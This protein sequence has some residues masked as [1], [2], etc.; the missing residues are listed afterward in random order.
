MSIICNYTFGTTTFCW[1]FISLSILFTG[2]CQ[3]QEP[4]PPGLQ[5]VPDE[6]PVLEPEEALGTFF[7]PPGYSIELVAAEP[8]V[9]D[10]VAIDFDAEGRIWVAEMRGYMPNVDAEG[11]NEP[12]GKIVVLEDTTGDGV[13]DKKTVYMDNLVLPRALKV[14]DSGVLVAAPPY[15]WMTRDTTGNLQADVVEVL[16][17][18]YGS[19]DVNPEVNP[20]GLLWGL[21]NWIYNTRYRGR[22]YYENGELLKE[23][24]RSLGQWGISM[25]DYGYIY[26]NSNE[27]PIAVDH[28]A[29]HYYSRNENLNRRR[30]VYES[31]Y[32]NRNIWPIRS[33][34]GVN[35]GY[36]TNVVLHE[37]D[38][39][40][41]R[42]TAA[43]SLAAY[44][45]DRLPDELRGDV[46][47][48]DP[49]GNLVQRFEIT[50]DRL[51]N[52][53]AR[54]PYHDIKAAFLSS[55]DE[56]FR[57][58]NI[59]SAPDGTLYIVD[60]Y[61][62][63]IQHR[64]YLTDYLRNEIRKRDLE[65]PLGLGRIYRIVHESKEPDT[66]PQFSGKTPEE[67]VTYLE[68]PNGWWRDT[69]QRLLV[70]RQAVSVSPELRSLVTE[71]QEDYTRLQALWTL[72]G[73]HA[74]DE[75]ILEQAMQDSSPHVRAAAIR[76]AEP[77]ISQPGNTLISSALNLLDDD[78]SVVRRQLAASLGELPSPQREE[79][80]LSVINRYG[81]DSL[82]VSLVVSGLSGRELAFLNNYLDQNAG[83]TDIT[84]TV[85]VVETLAVTILRS[86][87]SED[88]RTLLELPADENRPF[89]QRLSVLE[90][91]DDVAP[92][93]STTRV[94][95]LE[96]DHRPSAL[97]SLAEAD[98]ETLSDLASEVVER[99][100][101]P[102]K[103]KPQLPEVIPLTQAEQ[104]RFEQ[105]E[106]LFLNT[107]T[108]CHASDGQET[109]MAPSLVDS[110]WVLGRPDKLLRILLQGLEGEMLMP[111]VAYHSDEE[112]AAI[113]TY[114][115]RAWGNNASPVD[116]SD[117]SE[118]R[119]VTTGRERPW[120][121][122][123]L[124]AIR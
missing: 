120:T 8:L 30:G 62:G 13:M 42:F 61:R 67:L 75:E 57:P 49:A 39:T 70:E 79:A 83:K 34:S 98:Q 59:S 109:D 68:H 32:E 12:V 74:A 54:N 38:S 118:I 92:P 99:M 11:E 1:L 35:R 7:L 31:I 65:K 2:S 15:L 101:W 41:I 45:G 19:P 102:G 64:Y 36:R 48:P 88:I 86:G 23:D 53:T 89:W 104:A 116:P 95:R 22:F 77:F 113:V 63:V 108:A 44:R 3:Q 121:R 87:N 21:D 85:D 25:D 51:G 105:G 43:S 81:N 14:L 55:T 47:V 27:N 71:G 106:K 52:L 26:R 100:G 16:R 78:R 9:E 115:R 84:G 56:R 110:E 33:N 112:L 28:T 40:L 58:V 73:L 10:P 24:A 5:D 20:N 111:P 17:D 93:H 76:I 82:V 69:A 117:V 66:K 96:L 124:E 94:R 4:W 91:I 80:M 103:P 72:N 122:E 123:E 119:G 37:E 114:I 6:S 46:F 18:D 29:P 107:C 60:M 50:E 97:L 90:G